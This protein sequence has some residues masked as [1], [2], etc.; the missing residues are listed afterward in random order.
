MLT[1]KAL[2]SW[3]L[4]DV[5][6]AALSERR[7]LS[8]ISAGATE[9]FAMAQYT[10]LSEAEMMNHPEALVANRQEKHG[11]GHRGVTF[12]NVKLRD[13]V[14]AAVRQADVVGYNILAR[15]PE[16]GPFTEKV[17]DVY[18]IAPEFIFDSYLRRVIMFSQ[19]ERFKSMLRNRRVLLIGEPSG[20]AKEAVENRWQDELQV[21]IVGAIPIEGYGDISEV[22]SQ[23]DSVDFDLCLLA[24]GTN[25]LILSSYIAS[26]RGKVA[27]DIGFGMTSLYTNEVFFDPWLVK[28]IGLDRLMKM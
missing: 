12:P 18:G 25:A 16:G 17:F 15:I 13:E 3:E 21:T 8:I 27:F 6:I 19:P 9:T 24:A 20:R 7:P 1:S 22:K 2:H 4:L 11:F 14:V 28:F 26:T 5:I 23:I 10:L